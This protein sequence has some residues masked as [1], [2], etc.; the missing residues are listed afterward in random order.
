MKSIEWT[1]TGK[2]PILMKMISTQYLLSRF[3]CSIW[4][5]DTWNGCRWVNRTMCVTIEIVY[6][7]GIDS[8]SNCVWHREFAVVIIWLLGAHYVYLT[9]LELDTTGLHI[10]EY[11]VGIVFHLGLLLNFTFFVLLFFFFCIENEFRYSFVHETF[12]V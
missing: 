5:T 3:V 10:Y 7:F 12:C 2:K 6:N 1:Y 9:K 4:A 8:K 11:P